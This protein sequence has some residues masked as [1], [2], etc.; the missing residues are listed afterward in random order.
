MCVCGGKSD[1]WIRAILSD[2]G[3]DDND[4]DNAHD[5]V[6]DNVNDWNW[7]TLNVSKWSVHPWLCHTLGKYLKFVMFTVGWVKDY[8]NN[9]GNDADDQH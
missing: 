5:D 7:A 2:V 6:H 1:K 3:D 8:G 4:E 9:I